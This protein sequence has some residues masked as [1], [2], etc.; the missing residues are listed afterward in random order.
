MSGWVVEGLKLDSPAAINAGCLPTL[1]PLCIG[2][3]CQTPLLQVFEGGDTCKPG[4]AWQSIVQF[5]CSPGAADTL[6]AAQLDDTACVAKFAI[7][8]GRTWCALCTRPEHDAAHRLSAADERAAE[9]RRGGAADAQLPL[10]FGQPAGSAC[11]RAGHCAPPPTTCPRLAAPPCLPGLCCAWQAPMPAVY[12]VCWLPGHP[13]Q[14]ACPCCLLFA[15][16]QAPRARRLPT[17]PRRRHPLQPLRTHRARLP[18]RVQRCS[19]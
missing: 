16:S 4:V 5:S 12:G 19:L 17:H 15:A 18:G 1:R 14:N 9:A 10:Q 13:A 6:A 2:I 11:P 8:T 3:L 7:P